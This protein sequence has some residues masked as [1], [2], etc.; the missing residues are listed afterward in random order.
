MS[1]GKPYDA[2]VVVA[3]VWYGTITADNSTEAE[4]AAR[5]AF[6]EGDLQQCQEDIIHVHVRDALK[7]FKVSYAL[8]QGFAVNIEAANAA[9][10]EAV[11][12]A[13]LAEEHAM[14]SRSKTYVVSFCERNFYRITLTAASEDEA[15]E[16][17]E[18]LYSEEN[19]NL[20][21]F[22]CSVGGTDDWQAEEVRP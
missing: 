19:E 13:H 4:N 6:E 10:A 14:L 16:K 18:N 22:D 11:V 2:K 7:T 20:F 15:L 3:S 9:D 17:A 21:E 1:T 8:E 12:K 5:A